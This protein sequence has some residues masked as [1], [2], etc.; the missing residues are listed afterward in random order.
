MC[1]CV[2]VCVCVCPCKVICAR[3]WMRMCL[4]LCGCVW[5][6][7]IYKTSCTFCDRGFPVCPIVG[8]TS[9]CLPPD[10]CFV[11]AEIRLDQDR[12]SPETVRERKRER[13]KAFNLYQPL[14]LKISKIFSSKAIYRLRHPQHQPYTTSI[15]ANIKI[16]IIALYSASHH[17]EF[18]FSFD[19]FLRGLFS[20]TS[21]LISA[22]KVFFCFG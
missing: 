17:K 16:D 9:G 8:L 5:M 13:K 10:F 2:C 21:F 18:S 22:K 20:S 4:C 3:T 14:P 19:F 7:V 12:N 6:Y 15:A 11:F 1:V